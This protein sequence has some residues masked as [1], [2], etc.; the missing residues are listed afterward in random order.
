MHLFLRSVGFEDRDDS[1]EKFIRQAVKQALIDNRVMYD[2]MGKC[3]LIEIV[4]GNGFGILVKGHYSGNG[5]Y[6]MEYSYPYLESEAFANCEEIIIERHADKDSYAAICDEIKVGVSLIFYLQNILDYYRYMHE[7]KNSVTGKSVTLTAFSREGNVLLPVHKSD[8]QIKRSQKDAIVRD[9]LISAARQGDEVAME[10]LTIEEMDTYNR[11]SDRIRR[12]DVYSI[13][14]TTFMPCGVE[15]D[16]YAV[17]GTILD[18]KERRNNF[19]G[20]LLWLL[21]LE[22]NDFVFPVMI[23]QK[24]LLGEPQVGRRFKGRVW[25]SGKVNFG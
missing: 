9:K 8:T 17:I 3:G 21:E 7:K 25:M 22:C 23:C 14:D 19:T 1:V 24:D 15:C 5:R 18:C 6:V 4:C 12:E 10:S 13:V 2:E 16:Q 20:E 11:I